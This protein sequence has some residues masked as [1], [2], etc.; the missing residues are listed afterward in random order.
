MYFVH[1]A[2][3]ILPKRTS[4]K[5]CLIMKHVASPVASTD[6]F[7]MIGFGKTAWFR[8]KEVKDYKKSD[9]VLQTFA[10]CEE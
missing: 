10:V 1:S 2:F 7:S 3:E 4:A 9:D 8:G 6:G 5:F